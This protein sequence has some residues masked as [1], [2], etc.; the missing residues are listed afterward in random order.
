M[1]VDRGDPQAG[2]PRGGQHLDELGAVGADQRHRV[3]GL[4]AVL[5]Q[6]AHDAVGGGVDLAEGVGLAVG[7]VDEGRVGLHVGPDGHGHAGRGGLGQPVVEAHLLAWGPS[8]L[9]S[10]PPGASL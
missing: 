3:A 10:N 1:P 6:Q 2:A 7:I 5:A 9:P 4:Q 8:G